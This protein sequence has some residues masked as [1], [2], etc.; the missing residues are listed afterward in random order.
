MSDYRVGKAGHDIVL[1]SLTVLDPQPSTEGVQPTRRT[2]AA[3]GSVLDEGLFVEFEY[4]AL[5]DVNAYTGMLTDF[6]LD[7][8]L[9]NEV[10]VYVRTEYYEYKRYNGT[11]VRPEMGRDVRWRQYFPRDAVVLV[12]DLVII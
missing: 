5:E 1:G 7:D 6:G 8:A 11:A 10:T 4:S 12:K 2:F 3:S 9:T